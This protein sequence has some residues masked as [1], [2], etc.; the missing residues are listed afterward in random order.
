MISS[1]AGTGGGPVT[2]GRSRAGTVG[3]D[4]RIQNTAATEI[5]ASPHSAVRPARR[6]CSRPALTGQGYGRRPRRGILDTPSGLELPA[7]K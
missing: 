4:A 7:G 1:G 6:Q 2:P 3:S 5:T